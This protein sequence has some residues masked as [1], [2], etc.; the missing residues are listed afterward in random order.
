MPYSVTKPFAAVCAPRAPRSWSC[1]TSTRRCT[2]YWPEMVADD[3]P[4]RSCSAH[5]SGPASLLDASGAARR[6]C[7]DWDLMCSLMAA[8]QPCGSR[9]APAASSRCS[10]ATCSARWSA[11]STAA[12]S[13]PSCARRSCDPHGIDFHAGLRDPDLPRIA[14]LTGF[15]D[16]ASRRRDAERHSSQSRKPARRAATPASSTP[17]GLATV[18]EVPAVNGHGTPAPWRASSSRSPR[19]ACCPST[20]RTKMR[21]GRRSTAVDLRHSASRRRGLS[22]SALDDDGYRHGRPGRQ[23]R[24]AQHAGDYVVRDSSPAGSPTTTGYARRQRGSRLPRLSPLRPTTGGRTA[25]SP[26]S[27]S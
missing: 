18:A 23:P 16:D 3:H 27:P 24:L 5:E 9:G 21:S 15:D 6:R 17:S 26:E 20:L 7:C 14:D 1:S 22:A 10:T 2:T 11:A 19:D 8:Q 4:A 25:R 12:R 13:A